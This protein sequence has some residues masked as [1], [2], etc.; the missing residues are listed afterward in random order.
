MT[1][2]TRTLLVSFA[3]SI[4]IIG[5]ALIMSLSNGVNVYINTTER[6]TL[7]EYPLTINSTSFDLTSV[8]SNAMKSSKATINTRKMERCEGK[9]CCSKYVLQSTVE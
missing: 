9:R 8:M 3:G 5:I 7:S 1:K 4:G 2:K 6:E